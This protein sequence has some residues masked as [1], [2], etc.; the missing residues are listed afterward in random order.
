MPEP[1]DFLF[2]SPRFSHNTDLARQDKGNKR[3]EMGRLT[4]FVVGAGVGSA[5]YYVVTSSM[6]HNVSRADKRV[7]EIREELVGLVALPMNHVKN[8]GVANLLSPVSG[9]WN[10][11]VGTVSSA[12]SD[13]LGGGG[14][15]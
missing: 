5:Y 8:L 9:Y 10:G 13:Y 4:T 14:K 6:Q 7:L 3:S 15:N 2:P 1:S 12:I 11:M